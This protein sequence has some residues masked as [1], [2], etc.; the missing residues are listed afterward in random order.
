MTQVKTLSIGRI[1]PGCVTATTDPITGGVELLAP[2]GEKIP[3]SIGPCVFAALP[4]A[5]VATGIVA[6]VSDVGGSGGSLWVSDG[7]RWKPLNGSLQ[8]YTMP[9][10]NTTS[11]VTEALLGQV[12]VPA[13]VLQNG[14]RL[15]LKMS[16]SKSGTSET[17]T[18]RLRIGTAGTTVD[19]LIASSNALVTTNISMES[20][21][22]YRRQTATSVQKLGTSASFTGVEGSVTNGAFPAANTVPNMDTSGVYF[23]ITGAMSSTVEV[24][25]LEDF[26]V[27]MRAAT[28]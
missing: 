16:F 27:I 15:E 19:S 24:C 22:K 26:E 6:K 5:S 12:F 1:P 17:A 18:I 3:V 4:T 13:G 8:L 7:A 28:A 2:G 20:R 10:R 14:D 9:V 25:A 21:L 23:S 11:G